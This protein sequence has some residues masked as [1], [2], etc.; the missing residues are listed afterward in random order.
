MSN[1]IPPNLNLPTMWFADA[2]NPAVLKVGFNIDEVHI[3][4][5]DRPMLRSLRHRRLIY[6]SNHPTQAE[7]PVAWQIAN[8]MGARFYSMAARRAFDFGFGLVGKV[9]Q[10]TGG[11]SVIPGIADRES[12]SMARKMLSAPSGKLILY[13]EGE[14]MSSENDNLMPFQAGIVKLGLSAFEDARKIKPD[15]DITILPA[16]IKYVIKSPHDV[17]VTDLNNSID[18]IAKKLGVNPGERNLLRRFLMIGRVITEQAEAQ[19]N[20]PVTEDM[21]WDFRAGRLRHAMLDGVAER[22]QLPR[23]DKEADAIQKLRVL[24]AIIELKELR[25]PQCP[26]PKSVSKKDFELATKE[27]IR[28][29]D[30]VV[31]RRDYLVSYPSAE[32]FYEW[33]ARFESLVLG[34]TPRMLGG[35][36]SHLPRTAYVNFAK[37]FGLAEYYE[38]YKNDRKGTLQK[39]LDRLRDDMQRMLDENLK[40]SKPIVEPFD[41]GDS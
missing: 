6:F 9:F 32:R 26:I 21:D 41:V 40:R 38:E 2:V 8:A 19:Y 25:H 4:K 14:P 11:F 5:A 7:P 22:L 37:P 36:P 1:F 39:I 30:F 3:E 33:L 34:K 13:P 23:Y 28:A 27:V 12:M 16:F 20:L 31:M 10:A 18:V 35:E 24:T 15:A 29:Y 17:I